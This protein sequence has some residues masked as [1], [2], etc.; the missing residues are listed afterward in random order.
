MKKFAFAIVFFA[1]CALYRPVN[2]QENTNDNLPT[3]GNQEKCL[4]DWL[5]QS[6]KQSDSTYIKTRLEE[7]KKKIIIPNQQGFSNQYKIK[8]TNF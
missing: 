2:A 1:L 3:T 6:L 5:D 4:S 7:N 8:K